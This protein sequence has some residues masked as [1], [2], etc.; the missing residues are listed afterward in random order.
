M[1]K[2]IELHSLL[3]SI[4]RSPNVYFQPPPSV[5]LK[6]P[7]IIYQRSYVDTEHADNIPYRLQPRYSITFVSQDPDSPIPFAI[8]KLPTAKFDRAYTADGLNHTI[9]T[10]YY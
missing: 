5:K 10:I 6:Y 7:C 8:A 2:R 1:R 9:Y 4:L 3:V